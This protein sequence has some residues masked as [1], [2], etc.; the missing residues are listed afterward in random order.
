MIKYIKAHYIWFFWACLLYCF[1]VTLLAG[2]VLEAP[3]WVQGLWLLPVNLVS[4]PVCAAAWRE[5]QFNRTGTRMS[6]APQHFTLT[7]LVLL[8]LL[9]AAAPLC[10]LLDLL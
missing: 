5:M 1:G 8:A 7:M 9:S 4:W 10:L 2:G 6:P 3:S